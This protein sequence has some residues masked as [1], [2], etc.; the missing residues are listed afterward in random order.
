[1]FE[2][3]TRCGKEGSGA[4]SGGG[5]CRWREGSSGDATSGKVNSQYPQRGSR[6][7]RLRCEGLGPGLV[8]TCGTSLPVIS[9]FS[10]QLF[11]MT[12]D[13]VWFIGFM[14]YNRLRLPFT[15]AH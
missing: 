5:E 4:K 13:R 15:E 3:D 1:M 8:R 14:L 6:T 2:S 11:P 12:Q 10:L 7:D 9:V